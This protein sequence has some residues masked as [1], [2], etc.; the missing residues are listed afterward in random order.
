M[1][2]CNRRELSRSRAEKSTGSTREVTRSGLTPLEHGLERA[3]VANLLS[4]GVLLNVDLDRDC[5]AA[6]LQQ[7]LLFRLRNLAKAEHEHRCD[8]LAFPSFFITSPM[9]SIPVQ[10]WRPRRSY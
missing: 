8:H 4:R 7:R 9:A 5:P 6:G 10:R 3:R 1:M 2:G